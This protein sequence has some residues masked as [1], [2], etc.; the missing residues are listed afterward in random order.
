MKRIVIGIVICF[1]A[2][3]TQAQMADILQ[4][5]LKQIAA[6]Q[7]YISTVEKGYKIAQEG[8]TT[9]GD[10]KNGEFNLHQAFFNS[11][12]TVDPSVKNAEKVLEI[13]ALQT[14]ISKNFASALSRYQGSQMF[15][16]GEIQYIEKVSSTVL[17]T[18]QKNLSALLDVLTDGRLEM[19]DGERL[20]RINEI[21]NNSTEE[22]GFSKNFT[23]EGDILTQQRLRENGDLETVKRLYGIQ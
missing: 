9:I 21:Y 20:S 23:D 7:G 2:I 17:S 6:L 3:S 22:Y 8:L 12:K 14:S 15:S 5:M 11:L 18:S 1:S 10:I 4:T 13:I 19:D 16:Q